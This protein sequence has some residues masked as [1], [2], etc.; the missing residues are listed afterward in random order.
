M[1]L[2]I[3]FQLLVQWHNINSLKTE[4]S[5]W[6]KFAVIPFLALEWCFYF[7]FFEPYSVSSPIFTVY[8]FLWSK[9]FCAEWQKKFMCYFSLPIHLIVEGVSLSCPDF[10]GGNG[11]H[12]HLY[13]SSLWNECHKEMVYT[14]VL[15]NN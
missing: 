13:S 7:P 1:L 3:S 9:C 2:C 12:W 8:V 6:Y 4:I 14:S 15:N 10:H 5:T 11:L